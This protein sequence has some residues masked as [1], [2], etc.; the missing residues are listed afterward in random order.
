MLRSL[1][2]SMFDDER[3]ERRTIILI[4]WPYRRRVDNV[5]DTPYVVLFYYTDG[6]Q[7]I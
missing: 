5:S 2:H 6:E 1:Q 7:K 4:A 3:E